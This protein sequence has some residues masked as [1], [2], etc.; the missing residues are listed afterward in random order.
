[1][2]NL[3][4]ENLNE[5]VNEKFELDE[6]TAE[7]LATSIEAGVKYYKRTK[8]RLFMRGMLIG[9]LGATSVLSILTILVIISG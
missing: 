5:A 7:F 2:E 9:A 3:K 4:L 6:E 8:L 1:M